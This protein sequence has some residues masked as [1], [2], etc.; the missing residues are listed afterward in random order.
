MGWRDGKGEKSHRIYTLPNPM[1]IFRKR[2]WLD[3]T[4]YVLLLSTGVGTT[5]AVVLQNVL[6]AI[7]PLALLAGCNIANRQRLH[8][9]ALGQAQ[10]S[11]TTTEA[12][13]LQRLTHVEHQVQ[14]SPSSE[15]FQQIGRAHV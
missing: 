5:A 13:L 9:Q 12:N 8:Q 3:W 2:H 15:A 7:A 1:P 6:F 14:D 4:E 11:L 10:G